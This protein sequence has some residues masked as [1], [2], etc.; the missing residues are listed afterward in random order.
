[1]RILHVIGYF[2]PELGYE[3]YYLARE[4]V[5]Q[6]HEVYVVTSDR[7]WPFKNLDLKSRQ[8]NLGRTYID[9]I[10]LI[11]LKTYFEF[12][13][14]ILFKRIKKA[15]KEINPDIIHVHEPRQGL[16]GLMV[17]QIG[18]PYVTDIHEYSLGGI[19]TKLEYLLF[20]KHFIRPVLK[21]S[22]RVL[23]MTKET[24]SFLRKVF[25]YSNSIYIP[26]GADDERFFVSYKS[27]EK[28]RSVLGVAKNEILIIFSGKITPSK[29]IEIIIRN[30]GKLLQSGYPVK[31]LILGNGD[32]KYIESLKKVIN[33]NEMNKA[34]MFLP[35]VHPSELYNYFNAADVG[36]WPLSPTISIL[37]AIACGL[38][39]IVPNNDITGTIVKKFCGVAID[40][41]DHFS[42]LELLIQN[43]QLGK[44][45]RE[46]IRDY[47]LDKFSY[48]KIA[49]DIE[50]MYKEII[51]K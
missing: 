24:V 46:K 41:V 26:L 18:I 43:T 39:I 12:R 45:S 48:K 16:Y 34:V 42:D 37:E 4:Q 35:Q 8:R 2:Q 22:S 20:R 1:M 10:Y 25:S 29:G 6:G 9:G 36:Y 38:P 31:L 13:D 11:R 50:N 32:S 40:S 15:I 51:S 47:F 3:E 17:K 49:K 23:A 27:R 7:I 5:K 33:G 14:F 44:Y 19:K 30:V 28:Y 21:D